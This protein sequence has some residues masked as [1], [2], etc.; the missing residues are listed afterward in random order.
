MSLSNSSLAYLNFPT[1]VLNSHI[2]FTYILCLLNFQVIFKSCKLIPVL[3]GGILIQGKRY[4]LIDFI[5]ASVMCIG[6]IW[7][8]LADSQTSPNFH[9][10]GKKN[11]Q[12]NIKILI[13]NYLPLGVLMISLALLADALIGNVQEKA[14]KKCG[15]PNCEVVLYSYSMGLVYLGLALVFTGQ[16]IPSIQLANQV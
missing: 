7:F 6:L 16:L 11:I 10:A 14:I 8:T 2:Q 13:N 12:K 3:I 1:Q 4:G 5:A 9:P 15:A